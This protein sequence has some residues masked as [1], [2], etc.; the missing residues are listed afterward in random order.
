MFY[1]HTGPGHPFMYL[2]YYKNINDIKIYDFVFLTP[3]S[4]KFG[5]FVPVRGRNTYKLPTKDS[6]YSFIYSPTHAIHL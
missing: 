2:Q 6:S 4:L 1:L 3:F 5:P